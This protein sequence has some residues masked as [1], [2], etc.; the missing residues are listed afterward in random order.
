MSR[1]TG[2]KFWDLR[3]AILVGPDRR[4]R[5]AIDRNPDRA[6]G[7]GFLRGRGR[8]VVMVVRMIRFI[9]IA[10][11]EEAEGAGQKAEVYVFHSQVWWIACLLDRGAGRTHEL[12][13]AELSLATGV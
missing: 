10:R 3:R 2:A 11:C 12:R 8:A 6:R 7:R 4:R 1:A 13:G 9:V 5:R